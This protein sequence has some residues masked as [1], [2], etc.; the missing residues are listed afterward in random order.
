MREG[1]RLGGGR[2]GQKGRPRVP[3]AIEG[4]NLQSQSGKGE[5][6]REGVRIST[7][8]R[9]EGFPVAVVFGA[10]DKLCDRSQGV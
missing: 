4:F 8:Q 3:H 9:G 1:L 7:A 6:E 5:E 2:G 10:N